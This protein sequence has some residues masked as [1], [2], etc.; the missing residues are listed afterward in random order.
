VNRIQLAQGW[1][2]FCEASVN[3]AMKLQ[4]S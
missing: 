2:Q 4:V 1:F 3:T